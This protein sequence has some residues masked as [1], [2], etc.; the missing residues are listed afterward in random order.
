MISNLKPGIENSLTREV[1]EKDT[2][3]SFGVEHMP[4]L[5][6]SKIVAFMEYTALS[7]VETFLPE[8]Y[9]SV[10]TQI[11]IFHEKPVL[12]G[13]SVTCYSRLVETEGRKLVFEISLRN[14]YDL[15]AHATHTRIIIKNEAFKRMIQRGDGD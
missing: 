5:A 13:E 1:T 9:S 3:S 6:T 8:G 15:V 7:S 2:A 10:G 14:D 11:N 4:V 12:P